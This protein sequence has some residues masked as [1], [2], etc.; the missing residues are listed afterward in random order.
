MIVKFFWGLNFYK[1]VFV[2]LFVIFFYLFSRYF[3]ILFSRV[4]CFLFFKGFYCLELR[5]GG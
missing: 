4:N 2:G 1:E 5:G 3:S